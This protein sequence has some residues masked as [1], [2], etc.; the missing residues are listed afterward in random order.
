MQRGEGV[1]STWPKNR[2]GQPPPPCR[3]SSCRAEVTHPHVLD[4]HLCEGEGRQAIHAALTAGRLVDFFHLVKG[5]LE[6]YNEDSP[7]EALSDWY[8]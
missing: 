5:I 8:S 2:E 6:T 7:Y 3:P 4:D 1:L